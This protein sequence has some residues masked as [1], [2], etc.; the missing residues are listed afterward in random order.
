MSTTRKPK[1]LTTAQKIAAAKRP[2]AT[3]K[4]CL[5]GDLMTAYT[6]AA[7]ALEH[8]VAGGPTSL[9]GWDEAEIHALAQKADDIRAEMEEYSIEVLF[10][11]LPRQKWNQLKDK[12]PPRSNDDGMVLDEDRPYGVDISTFFPEALAVCTVEPADLTPEMW[13]DLLEDKL[14]D[15]QIA[16]ACSAVWLINRGIVSVPFSPAV[17][18]ILSSG[19]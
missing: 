10:E 7:E 17:S 8:A 15:G 3:E 11:A 9:A 1:K 18:K 19:K 13:A 16:T 14:S 2:R 4:L 5:R 12:H 6:E